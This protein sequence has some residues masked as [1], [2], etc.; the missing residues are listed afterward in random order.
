VASTRLESIA[1]TENPYS[2]MEVFGRG[3]LA[4]KSGATVY[5]TK[6]WPVS[7]TP[8]AVQ[9]CTMEI[10]AVFNGTDVYVDPISYI[11]KTHAVPVRCTDIKFGCIHE[12]SLISCHPYSTIFLKKLY[13]YILNY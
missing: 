3:H 7:V 13:H 2:L 9:N 5:I 1:G 6:C 10:P 12:T 4:T 11:I 8:R